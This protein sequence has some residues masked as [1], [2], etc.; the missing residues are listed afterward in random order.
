M[1]QIR[2]I[3]SGQIPSF[4]S[5]KM[6]K[7]GDIPLIKVTKASQNTPPS[8]SESS[9][10]SSISNN[11]FK[12]TMDRPRRSSLKKKNSRRKTLVN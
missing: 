2:Q 6:Q 8:S 4:N 7:K 11:S 9:S 10:G 1:L 5:F 3:K 12:M